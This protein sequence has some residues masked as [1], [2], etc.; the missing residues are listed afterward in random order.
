[1]QSETRLT[2]LLCALVSIGQLATV[3]YLP[4]LPQISQDL[5][6]SPALTETTIT[7]FLL[8]FG[9]SQLIYGPLS[10][11]WGR[12]P[13]ILLGI[14]LYAVFSL[15]S[16]VAPNIKTLLLARFLEGVGAGAI[17]ALAR[18]AA[19]DFFSGKKLTNVL[20]YTA[21]A[22]S[23]GSMISP[24]LGGWFTVYFTWR[25][26]FYFLC[27]YALIFLVLTYFWLPHLKPVKESGHSILHITW[28]RY[29]QLL[30]N[31]EYL[32]FMIGGCLSVTGIAFYY[33]ASAF[34]FEHSL[35]LSPK[36]YGYLFLFTS[37]TFILGSILNGR[38][39]AYERQRLYWASL[40]SVLALLILLLPGLFGKISILWVLLP[41]ML[42]LFCAGIIFPTAMT[43]AVR[44]VKNIAGTASALMGCF[45][46]LSYSIASA[47]MAHLSQKTQAPM[48]LAMLV[49]TMF[50]CGFILIALK[51]QDY[52]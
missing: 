25:T 2:F 28:S 45:Q 24:T 16:A 42:Y 47:V 9:F 13:I 40:G 27:L 32:L 14:C 49:T 3:I 43:C 11:H 39:H 46:I 51:Y 4:S 38:L 26:N 23:L 20:S 29:R 31:R 35:G 37:S 44:L 5:H 17:T 34:I 33:S 8:A 10:D 50:A 41:M 30:K 36:T 1:M 52:L 7:L 12:K 48:A 15:I 21:M 18:A 6:S 19:N 22:A